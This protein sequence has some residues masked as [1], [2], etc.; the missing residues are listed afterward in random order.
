[1]RWSPPFTGLPGGRSQRFPLDPGGTGRSSVAARASVRRC[2]T[3][4][5][6]EGENAMSKSQDSK[7]NVKKAPTK[8]PKEKKEAKRL[9][10]AEKK[11]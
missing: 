6:N 10:K 11:Y 3:I 5:I 8:T 2:G 4:T 1:M 7:K 9:K